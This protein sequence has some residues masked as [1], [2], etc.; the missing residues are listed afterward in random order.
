MAGD[1]GGVGCNLVGDHTLPD[2]LGVREA[3]VLLG[4]D[5]AEHGGAIPADHGG[6][7][8]AGDVV[9]AGSDVGDER[10]EQ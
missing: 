4:S 5:V 10:A 6:T 7:D 2:V 8:R 9:V 3:E 1:I